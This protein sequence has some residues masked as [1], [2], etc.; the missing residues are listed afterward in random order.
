MFSNLPKVKVTSRSWIAPILLGIA[1]ALPPTSVLADEPK[2]EQ[3]SDVKTETKADAKTD[4]KTMKFVRQDVGAYVLEVPEGWKIGEETPW[5]ARDIMQASAFATPKTEEKSTEKTETA[6]APA[7]SLQNY[8]ARL[9][10]TAKLTSMSAMTAP[11]AHNEPWEQLYK[12]SLFFIMQ[13]YKPGEVKAMPFKVTKAKQGYEACS[14]TME[15]KDGGIRARH[16]VLRN[17]DGKI[18]ALSVKFPTAKGNEA[19]DAAFEHMV[20]TASLK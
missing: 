19:Q 4:A 12:T 14:W 15:D 11:G 8:I 20:S 17:S 9:S 5:G 3:K 13:T 6:T 2:P 16:V 1:F 7:S 10:A 18:L